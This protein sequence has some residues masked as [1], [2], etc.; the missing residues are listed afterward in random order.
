MKL[1]D[2]QYELLERLVEAHRSAPPEKRAA[3]VVSV[4]HNK[5]Q[6]SFIHSRVHGLCVEGSLSDAKVLA[7]LGLVKM[8]GCGSSEA[9]AVL[10]AGI[11][12]YEGRRQAL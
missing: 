3:F 9:L 4:T 10:P 11:S 5:P 8:S 7:H 1:E 12:A 6:A 2:P